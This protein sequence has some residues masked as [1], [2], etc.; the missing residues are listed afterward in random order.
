M[1]ARERFLHSEKFE[2][3]RKIN[4]R[5]RPEVEQVILW[6]MRLHPD[7]RPKNV[8]Q[9]RAALFGTTSLP[10]STVRTE[11]RSKWK[12]YIMD[13]ALLVMAILGVATALWMT[14]VR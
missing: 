11:A 1:T 2:P 4:P 12:Q 3:P 6:A 14:M 8:L 13:V 7:E 10:R 9:L 5:I